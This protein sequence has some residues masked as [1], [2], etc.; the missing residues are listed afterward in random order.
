[1]SNDDVLYG[2]R[3]RLYTLAARSASVR[4]AGRWAS[5]TRPTTAGRCG[6]TAGG[7]RRC[8]SGSA[9][10]RPAF[11]RFLQVRHSR[12][13]RHLHSYLGYYNHQRA[14]TGRRTAGR[15]PPTL[16]TVRPDGAQMSFNCRHNSQSVQTRPNRVD[17]WKRRLR[18]LAP[19]RS[20]TAV[21]RSATASAPRGITHGLRRQPRR[22][23]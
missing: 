17:S 1:V 6:S 12:L 15:P 13:K 3:L 20:G 16:S 11:A 8:G 23:P 2:Y 22:L 4:P 9:G 14:H 19:G 18:S 10:W 21:K 5:T 7:W